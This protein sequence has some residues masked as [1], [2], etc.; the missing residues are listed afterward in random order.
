ME[1]IQ[2]NRGERK[3]LIRLSTLTILIM[4][5]LILL[6]TGC[7][8]TCE[9]QYSYVRH[10]PVYTTLDDLRKSVTYKE[11]V[12]I[13]TPGALYYKDGYVYV[14]ESGKGI[15]VINN[16]DVQNPQPIGFV[17]IPGNI[18]LAAKGN[19]LYAD[20]YMDLVVLD[21]S[22]PTDIHEV[23]RVED[24]FENLVQLGIYFDSGRGIVT[25]WTETPVNEIQEVDCEAGDVAYYAEDGLSN[26]SF[27]SFDTQGVKS[28]SSETGEA[29]SMARFVVDGSHLYTVDHSSLNLFDVSKLDEPQKT[30]RINIGWGIETIF[31]YDNKL[32]IGA[33]DGMYIFDNSNPSSPVQ[34]SRY[35]HTTSCDPVVVQGDY[36]YVTLRSGTECQGFTNQLDVVNVSDPTNPTLAK[37]YEMTNPHGLA[38]NGTCL[39]I[40]EGD[41]GLKTF[42]V[43]AF[44]PTKITMT[45]HWQNIH[46]FDVIALPDVLLMVGNDGFHQYRYNCGAF[47]E[48]AS[49]ISFGR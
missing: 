24:A 20:S 49:T 36:A 42:D 26:R 14:N 40:C 1:K 46:A 15:H 3:D 30:D 5:I 48:Y 22:N 23:R 33:Q 31:P 41:F 2:T 25:D 19:F 38:I 12:A 7:S 6:Y 39:F 27:V 45:N 9:R 4:L 13:E 17:E 8:E 21:I 18:G 34:L 28:G 37:T 43:G 11:P 10:D 35:A 47:L 16:Q 29:G 44:D 32:F